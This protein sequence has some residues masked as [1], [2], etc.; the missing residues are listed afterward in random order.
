MWLTA[1]SI[2]NFI[3][4]GYNYQFRWSIILQT[5]LL[6]LWCF[7]TPVVK[8]FYVEINCDRGK[9]GKQKMLRLNIKWLFCTIYWVTIADYFRVITWNGL[10]TYS[11]DTM[12]M[13]LHFSKICNIDELFYC[14]ELSTLLYYYIVLTLK[15]YLEKWRVLGAKIW[16]FAFWE[17]K[18]WSK[19]RLK[20]QELSKIANGGAHERCRLAWK[21]GVM[22]A[23]HPHTIVIIYSSPHFFS[24]DQFSVNYS[25]T[26]KKLCFYFEITQRYWKIV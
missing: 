5:A 1:G 8:F 3:S 7:N 10:S 26:F 2:V 19:S 11:R 24:L 6:E 15:N 13:D 16:I 23:A 20:M 12:Y 4:T 25:F 14:W 22:T 17:L 18:F 21:K 9:Y